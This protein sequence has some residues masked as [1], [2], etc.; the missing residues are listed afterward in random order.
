MLLRKQAVEWTQR[1]QN[2]RISGEIAYGEEH[3]FDSVSNPIR[4]PRDGYPRSGA[5]GVSLT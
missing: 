3:V 2:Q 4:E 1:D 5:A